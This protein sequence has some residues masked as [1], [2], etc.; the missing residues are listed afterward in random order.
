MIS[1]CAEH[2]EERDIFSLANFV[3][4]NRSVNNKTTVASIKFSVSR[5]AK[6]QKWKTSN[7]FRAY[8]SG[9]DCATPLGSPRNF[10]GERELNHYGKSYCFTG[11][12][13]V[14]N[15]RPPKGPATAGRVTA[16]VGGSRAVDK[17]EAKRKEE[18][19]RDGVAGERER[20]DQCIG[21]G[22]RSLLTA[23]PSEVGQEAATRR[24]RRGKRIETRWL[25]AGRAN[26]PHD[27]KMSEIISDRKKKPNTSQRKKWNIGNMGQAIAEVVKCFMGYKKAST[28]F[29]V[30]RTTLFR[31]ALKNEETPAEASQST[32]IRRPVLPPE[33]EKSGVVARKTQERNKRRLESS[34]DDYP[35]NMSDQYSDSDLVE[36]G[37]EGISVELSWGRWWVS[38]TA[39]KSQG[40][41]GDS[42]PLAKA[43]LEVMHYS[44]YW[45]RARAGQATSRHSRGRWKKRLPGAAPWWTPSS[46]LRSVLPRPRTKGPSFQW[47]PNHL[48]LTRS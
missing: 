38:H 21:A 33:L 25:T 31:M 11:E 46:F 48:Q 7:L 30:T 43:R 23:S 47:D 2:N 16:C 22:S 10:R 15:S 41:K 9:N 37:L 28:V 5:L 4:N 3:L 17:C 13:G 1:K 29:N 35:H 19:E 14:L 44:S 26:V 36:I 45:R 42:S 20:E 24:L 18:G 40:G 34:S 32:L 8:I 27:M 39:G 6:I 12:A